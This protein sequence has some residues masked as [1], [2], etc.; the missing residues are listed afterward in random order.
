MQNQP[1]PEAEPSTSFSGTRTNSAALPITNNIPRLDSFD[2]GKTFFQTTK[3]THHNLQSIKKYKFLATKD[4]DDPT[5]LPHSSFKRKK[6]KIHQ[7]NYLHLL[8]VAADKLMEKEGISLDYLNSKTLPKL[9]YSVDAQRDEDDDD[10]EDLSRKCQNIM[11][12]VNVETKKDLYLARFSHSNSYKCETLNLCKKCFKAY[13]MENYCFYCNAIYR[14]FQ[15]N[16]QYFDNK[17]WILCEYCDRWQ[18]IKCEEKK[19]VFKNLEKLINDKEFKYICP[20]CRSQNSNKNK[21]KHKADKGKLIFF[22]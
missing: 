19:G 7:E 15:F 12:A 2:K 11:C 6:S 8:I 17:K 4:I 21:V 3:K 9:H 10:S 18:H 14:D 22:H 5:E 13:E 20:F 1:S 16:E